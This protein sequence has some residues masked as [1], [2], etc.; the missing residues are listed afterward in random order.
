MKVISYTQMRND[1]SEILDALRAGEAIVITQRG[2]PDL[3]LNGEVIEKEDPFGE[4]MSPPTLAD[5]SGDKH[6]R[7]ISITYADGNNVVS[8]NFREA[9]KRTKWKHAKTIKALGDK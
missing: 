3:M 2:K 5:E 9:L 6:T 4:I 8:R 7:V 1:L